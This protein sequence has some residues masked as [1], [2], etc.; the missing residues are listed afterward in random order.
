MAQ[1][2]EVREGDGRL[3]VTLDDECG[4]DMS[5][6]DLGWRSLPELDVIGTG[7]DIVLATS[8]AHEWRVV[9]DSLR[10][11]AAA[12]PL[13]EAG[14][15][16][17]TGDV[18]DPE[19]VELD[20]DELSV[21][22]NGAPWRWFPLSDSDQFWFTLVPD[23][24]LEP[25]V[26]LG[27]WMSESM[28]GMVWETGLYRSGPVL[29][30]YE[31]DDISGGSTWVYYG[32]QDLDGRARAMLASAAAP[33]DLACP[34]AESG[35]ELHGCVH[36]GWEVTVELSDVLS[37]ETVA[38]F[39]NA[40]GSPATNAHPNSLRNKRASAGSTPTAAGRRCPPSQRSS[41]T[42]ADRCPLRWKP[43]SA[44][45]CGQLPSRSS[46]HR[47]RSTDRGSLPLAVSTAQKSQPFAAPPFTAPAAVEGLV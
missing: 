16:T 9:A 14:L 29:Y 3:V 36:S 45:R 18:Y 28:T 7:A 24:D 5:V 2:T 40:P 20:Q 44:R 15:N 37:D 11:D 47:S 30:G 34:L 43:S 19:C 32:E 10:P 8:S 13:L 23:L 46:R 41:P 38:A 4:L 1:R 25:V 27:A 39:L 21:T 35:S 22:L 6:E 17:P 33:Y 12:Y 31:G 26:S 42:A